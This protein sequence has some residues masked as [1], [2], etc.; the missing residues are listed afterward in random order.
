M[1][2]SQ[3]VD[4]YVWICGKPDCG[5]KATVREYKCGCIQVEWLRM[6]RSRTSDCNQVPK[7]HKCRS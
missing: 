6:G 7:P 1:Q 2:H 3:L 4:H 5:A